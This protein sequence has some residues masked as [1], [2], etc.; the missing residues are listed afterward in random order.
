MKLSEAMMLG[1]SLRKRTNSI[2]LTLEK[3]G[4][5]DALLAEHCSPLIVDERQGKAT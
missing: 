1:D 3:D 4:W 2:Y 5:C